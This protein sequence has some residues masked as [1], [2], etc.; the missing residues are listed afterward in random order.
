MELLDAPMSE[1]VGSLKA[2][3]PLDE[4]VGSQER[5]TVVV[6]APD[7]TERFRSGQ[8]P[9]G[10]WTGSGDVRVD[11]KEL[12]YRTAEVGP[13]RVVAAVD[14]TRSLSRLHSIG[15]IFAVLLLPLSVIVG[16]AAYT[17]AGLMYRPLRKLTGAAKA[18]A[19]EGKIGQLDDPKDADFSPL[20]QE[21][22]ALLTRIAGEVERQ[23][24][25]VS[26][27][28]YDLRTPLTVIRGRLETALMQGNAQ[29]YPI[30][31]R[32]AIR[33]AERLS[34]MAESILRIGACPENS[35][36]IELSSHLVG[37]VERWRQAFDQRGATIEVQTQPCN[38]RISG[39]EWDS[40]LDNLF[41][42]AFKYG[43]DRCS[44]SLSPGEEIAL[45]M[46]DNGPG[47]PEA[48]RDRVFE[49]FVRVDPSRGSSGH[50]L[51]LYLCASI[52]RRCGGAIRIL[53][54]PGM[55]VRVTLP[56]LANLQTPTQAQNGIVGDGSVSMRNDGLTLTV[57]GIRSR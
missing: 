17:A 3:E 34:A 8:S 43:G 54:E 1:V 53:A 36:E 38:A 40:V 4:E 2:G 18:L 39:D 11:G 28:A 24:R 45:E 13:D 29:E 9:I 25:L 50:G 5:V 16:F 49:R 57:R 14:W 27:V 48:E 6:F 30:A 20:A 15:A 21:I 22:N 7:G 26:D 31:M 42:N 32:T 47:V 35:E 19:A 51:G 44:V 33:E 12:M 56:A 37:A 46:R 52:V 10:T 23:E 41:D 55:C